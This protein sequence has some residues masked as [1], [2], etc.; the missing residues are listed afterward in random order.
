MIVAVA[1]WLL[2]SAVSDT[3]PVPWYV[4]PLAREIHERVRAGDT[5]HAE[6]LLPE[7]RPYP[8]DDEVLAHLRA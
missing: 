2:D 7:E 3:V 6:E 8:V 4:T 5:E 1:F